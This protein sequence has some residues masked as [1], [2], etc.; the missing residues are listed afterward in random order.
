MVVYRACFDAVGILKGYYEMKS[1]GKLLYHEK[2][3]VEFLDDRI[4]ETCEQ[5]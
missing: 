3:S 5:G 1:D 2:A 4:V